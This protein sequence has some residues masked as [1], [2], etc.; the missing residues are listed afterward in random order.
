MKLLVV[1]T[2]VVRFIGTL[3]LQILHN[4]HAQTVQGFDGPRRVPAY[5]IV[6]A[7]RSGTF[8]YTA[9]AA[10]SKI[11][12]RTSSTLKNVHPYFYSDFKWLRKDVIVNIKSV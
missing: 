2:E 7:R 9:E 10:L 1:I 6:V 11:S 5:S 12:V 3:I 4:T 8:R